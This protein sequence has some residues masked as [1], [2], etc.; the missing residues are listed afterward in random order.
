MRVEGGCCY[1]REQSGHEGV[2]GTVERE[3]FEGGEGGQ[4]PRVCGI[5]SWAQFWLAF[6]PHE[7]CCVV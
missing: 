2:A 1:Q 7:L 3:K 5:T 6:Q 4:Q